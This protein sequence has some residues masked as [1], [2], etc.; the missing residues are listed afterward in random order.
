M[1][2]MAGRTYA[3]PRRPNVSTGALGAAYRYIR[4]RRARS[5][6]AAPVVNYPDQQHPRQRSKYFLLELAHRSNCALHSMKN[7]GSITREILVLF[8]Y[9]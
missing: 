8:V 7:G 5:V 2:E 1:C 4:H 6:T 3:M 9:Q